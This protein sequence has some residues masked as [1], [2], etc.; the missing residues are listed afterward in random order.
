MTLD[1]PPRKSRWPR[2]TRFAL[3]LVGQAAER[4]YREEIVASRSAGGRGEFD[5]ARKAW[6]DRHSLQPDD[7]LYLAEMAGGPVTLMTI[8]AALDTCGKTK[9]EAI[10]AL[11]RL[12]DAG[13]I[14]PVP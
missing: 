4:S 11:E 10:A 13:M 7:G 5:A 1:Q 8:V 2:S 9:V 12:Q 6:A 14:S 3:S